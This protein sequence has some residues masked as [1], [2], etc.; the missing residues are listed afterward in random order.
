MY[1][2]HRPHH[3]R[4][5]RI[6]GSRL[7]L[8]AAAIVALLAACGSDAPAA[9]D[10]RMGPADGDAIEVAAVDN[11]FEPTSLELA[12][13]TEVTIEVTNDGD[14]PHNLVID[15]LGLSTGT[16]EPGGVATATFTVPDTAVTY[17]CSFHSGMEGVLQP[18]A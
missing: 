12:A 14:R 2:R 17:Y 11:D 7:A 18:S 6:A 8:P 1:D 15:E 9:G 13:G 16:L 5:R 3:R 4:I 10:V